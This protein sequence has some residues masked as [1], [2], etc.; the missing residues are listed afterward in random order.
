MATRVYCDGCD[1][2]LHT[3]SDIQNIT[4]SVKKNGE[5]SAASGAYELCKGCAATL[6]SQSNPRNWAR[7]EPERAA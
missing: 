2:Q 3:D 1:E 7:C 6:V 4:V 5:I